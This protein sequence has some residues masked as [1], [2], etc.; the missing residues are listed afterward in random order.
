MAFINEYVSQEDIAKY[1]LDELFRKYRENDLKYTATVNPTIEN[2]TNWT[3]DRDREIWL[4]RVASVADPN[5]E[6][7]STTREIIFILYYRTVNIEV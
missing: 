3:I 1:G 2:P 6:F 4:K 5:F 7:P